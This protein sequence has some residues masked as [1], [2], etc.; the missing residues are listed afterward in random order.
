[1]CKW[2]WANIRDS[3][4]RCGGRQSKRP[5]AQGHAHRRHIWSAFQGA[6][7][8]DFPSSHEW[9]PHHQFLHA[10]VV[11]VSP[12]PKSLIWQTKWTTDALSFTSYFC[13]YLLTT[14]LLRFSQK[15]VSTNFKDFLLRKRYYFSNLSQFY[16]LLLYDDKLIYIYIYYLWTKT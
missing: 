2:T 13:I 9:N 11:G 3:L 8:P 1:M 10:G 12:G 7:S 16:L 4:N 6:E 5:R 15:N 14:Y